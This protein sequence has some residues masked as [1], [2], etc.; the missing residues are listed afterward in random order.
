MPP[1]PARC[2]RHPILELRLAERRLD[3]ELLGETWLSPA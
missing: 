1:M 3:V 2:E